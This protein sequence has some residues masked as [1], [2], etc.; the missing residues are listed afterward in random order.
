MRVPL[1]KPDKF[2]NLDLHGET[3]LIRR[4]AAAHWQQIQAYHALDR[5]TCS[6]PA[7]AGLA[8][9]WAGCTATAEAIMKLQPM[10]DLDAGIVMGLA[11]QWIGVIG[12]KLP[13]AKDVLFDGVAAA[14]GRTAL[15]LLD[16]AEA[17]SPS[18]RK[19]LELISELRRYSALSI[20]DAGL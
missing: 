14:M 13:D 12:D 11:N 9:T 5:A 4:M 2:S 16:R 6:A 10:D 1:L 18:P 19:L 17:S 20:S 8:E 3:T 15:H 7:D